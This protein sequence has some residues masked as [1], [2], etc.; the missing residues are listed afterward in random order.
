MP[1]QARQLEIGKPCP[2]F[3][4]PSVDG[5]RYE[6]ASFDKSQALLVAFICNHCPYVLAI[7]DRLLQI[8]RSF[9]VEELQTVAICSNDW[10]Q[11]PED[12]PDKLLERSLRKEFGF[13]YLI[14]E[15]QAVAHRF[16]AVCTPDLFL[17]DHERKLF[18][19]GRIDDSWKDASKATSNEMHYAIE[20]LLAG[21]DPPLEQHPTIGCSIKWKH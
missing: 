15:N 19:H 3:S 10:A 21:E 13:P 12:A 4:L 18:Y 5:R 20:L 17:Y 11:Y 9:S 14:D 1:I 2:P 6:L 7:E 8:A 16:D